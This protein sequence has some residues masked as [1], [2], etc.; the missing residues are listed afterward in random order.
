MKTRSSIGRL[1][2][3]KLGVVLR[4][5]LVSLV[6]VPICSL[7]LLTPCVSLLELFNDEKEGYE[8]GN[9][10]RCHHGLAE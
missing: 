7:T 5:P 6:I 4:K 3:A 9:R 2:E 10:R 8:D 1:T